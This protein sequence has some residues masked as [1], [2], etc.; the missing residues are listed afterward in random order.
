MAASGKCNGES[1]QI[2]LI[3]PITYGM[4]HFLELS[5]LRSFHSEGKVKCEDKK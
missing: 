1:P 3:K 5:K 2:A 4:L